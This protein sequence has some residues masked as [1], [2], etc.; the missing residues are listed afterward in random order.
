VVAVLLLL[1]SIAFP[2]KVA[3]E[4]A[5]YMTTHVLTSAHLWGEMLSGSRR[6][7]LRALLDARLRAAMAA[8]AA[9][10]GVNPEAVP[11]AGVCEVQCS[12]VVN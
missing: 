3:A 1:N 9:V 6:D 10:L 4:F 8:G 12:S 5:D 11:M 7:A 2:Q